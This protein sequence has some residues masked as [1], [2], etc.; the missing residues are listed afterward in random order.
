MQNIRLAL[1]TF[2]T[3]SLAACGG[4]GGTSSSST[5]TSPSTPTTPAVTN[6]PPSITSLNF[7]PTFGI[8]PTVAIALQNIAYDELQIAA[9]PETMRGFGHIKEKNVVAAKARE[10]S[11]LAA[12]RTPAGEKLAAE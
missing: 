8:A 3:F 11:L 7:A 5:P 2:V 4:G 6:H 9:V 10:A 12:Y 1:V